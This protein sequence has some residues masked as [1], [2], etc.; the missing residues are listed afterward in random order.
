MMPMRRFHPDRVARLLLAGIALLAAGCSRPPEPELPEP[1]GTLRVL[2]FEPLD[3]PSPLYCTRPL[4]A[5][6]LEHVTPPLGRLDEQ[7]RVQL[8]LASRG[9]DNGVW[10]DYTLRRARWE[11]GVPVTPRDLVLTATL[12]GDPRVKSPARAQ[13]ELLKQATTADDSTVRLEYLTIYSHRGRDSLLFPLPAHRVPADLGEERLRESPFSTRPLACGPFRILPDPNVHHLVLA[14][15][16]G[17]GFAPARLDTVRVEES[18]VDTAVR[19]FKRGTADALVDLPA[20]RVREVQN[21]GRGVRIVALVGRSYLF[22]TWNLRDARFAEPAV[23]R[24]AAQAVDVRRMIAT[25]SYGQGDPARGPLT[26]L[27]GFADTT[28]TLRY[29]P[30]AAARALEDAGW[31]P[32]RDGVRERRGERLAFHLLAPFEE[33]L[34]VAT[35]REVAHD[36]A[37]IGMRAEVVPLPTPLVLQRLATGQFETA[38]GQWFPQP[39]VDLDPVWRSDATDQWNFGGYANPGVDSLLTRMRHELGDADRERLLSR[40]QARVYADQPY[41]FLFQNPHFVVLSPR[42]RGAEPTVVSPFWNLPQWWIPRR[43]RAQ[44]SA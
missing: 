18:E 9:V 32:G 29:D 37:R 2:V 33:P 7:G 39:G 17:S 34:R 21:Q 40:F 26:A 31:R 20:E 19:D 30:S 15:N 4:T 42:L 5:Q 23:R 16:D 43:L 12:L 28:A 10:I 41:L 14:R 27:H 13:V 44:P 3:L 35:A 24:A 11:D 22:M 25:L 1:G 8:L 38:M 36:L 6:L